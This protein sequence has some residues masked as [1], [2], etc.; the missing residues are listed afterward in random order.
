MI[1]IMAMV[2]TF[3]RMVIITWVIGLT[4]S[5]PAGENQSTGQVKSTKACGST[6]NSQEAEYEPSRFTMLI[7]IFKINYARNINLLKPTKRII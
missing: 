5:G 1:F 2:D 6:A 7:H 3:T 4:G